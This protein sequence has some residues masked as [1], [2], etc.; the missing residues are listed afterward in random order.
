MIA[1]SHN[2][3]PATPRCFLPPFFFFFYLTSIL[4]KAARK[5]SLAIAVPLST[6]RASLIANGIQQEVKIGSGIMGKRTAK[7][8]VIC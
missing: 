8:I 7:S 1:T 5:F 6:P 3:F 4:P 2:G